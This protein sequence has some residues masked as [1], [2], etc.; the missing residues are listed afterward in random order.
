MQ[1]ASYGPLWTRVLRAN[2]LHDTP[3]LFWG[4]SIRHG[5]TLT[6]TPV[7]PQSLSH[8]L[9]SLAA[10]VRGDS[11]ISNISG[12]PRRLAAAAPEERRMS[13]ILGAPVHQ[14][15]VYPDFD[16]AL[17]RFAGGGIGPFHIMRT[18]GIGRYRSEESVKDRAKSDGLKIAKLR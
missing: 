2:R 18:G 1:S 15:Y 16:A 13:R 3:S 9:P 11:L 12:P 10:P 8:L 7:R 6:L 4:T 5:A 17:E 14:A